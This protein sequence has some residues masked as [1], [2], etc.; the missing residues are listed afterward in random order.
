MSSLHPVNPKPFLNG[1]VGRR[2]AIKL[3][4]GL[5]YKG[6][7]VSYDDYMNFRLSQSE[8]WKGKDFK[9]ALGDLLVRCNNV[10]YVQEIEADEPGATTD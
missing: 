7:L 4:W 5:T 10:L 8:E 6:T 9:G 1:L 3:K 2:V